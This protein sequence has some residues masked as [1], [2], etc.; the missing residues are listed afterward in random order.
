MSKDVNGIIEKLQ[1]AAK[2]HGVALTFTNMRVYFK[3]LEYVEESMDEKN[4][5]AM[6]DKKILKTFKGVRFEMTTVSFARKFNVAPS[7]I[8][9]TLR[10]LNTCGVIK[11]IINSPNPSVIEMYDEYS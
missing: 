1:A 4:E 6:E 9:D 7:L 10:K 2:K 5:E 3:L 11:Y 8:T